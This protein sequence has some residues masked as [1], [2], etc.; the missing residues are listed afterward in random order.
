MQHAVD[1][2]RNNDF[3]AYCEGLKD[4]KKIEVFWNG[5][6]N[7]EFS[8]LHDF[9]PCLGKSNNNEFIKSVKFLYF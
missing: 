7:A 4:N 1:F 9:L 8:I 2:A 3:D 5:C 6:G